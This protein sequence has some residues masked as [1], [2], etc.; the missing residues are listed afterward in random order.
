MFNELYNHPKQ[1]ED[2][3]IKGWAFQ[4]KDVVPLQAAD[5]LAYE[6]FKLVENQIIDESKKYDVRRSMRDLMGSEEGKYLDY[7]GKERLQEWV[8]HHKTQFDKFV[9]RNE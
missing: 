2:W 4:G 3:R 1:R 8:E 7:W 5:V 9:G 6:L